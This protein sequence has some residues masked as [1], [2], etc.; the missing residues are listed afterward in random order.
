MSTNFINVICLYRRKYLF[1]R[2]LESSTSNCQTLFWTR[3]TNFVFYLFVSID[4]ILK[5]L[6]GCISNAYPLKAC[7]IACILTGK[8]I[9][10]WMVL[11][12]GLIPWR[13]AQSIEGVIDTGTDLWTAQLIEYCFNFDNAIC[14]T[15]FLQ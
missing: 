1:Q 4:K 3:F 6:K 11:N 12:G 14:Q 2:Q 10:I 7:T 9:P 15:Y 5:R 8:G 13:E